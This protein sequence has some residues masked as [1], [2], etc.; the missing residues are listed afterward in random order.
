MLPKSPITDR[1]NVV[2]EKEIQ[3]SH[4][5]ELY[6]KDLKMDVG[7]FF[8]SLNKIGLY[9]CL[10][11]GY[12][13]FYPFNVAGDDD[14]YQQLDKF[15]WYYMDSKWEHVIAAQFV[16]SGEKV[17][18]IGCARGGFLKRLK[19]KGALVTGLELNTEAAQ[20]CTKDGFKVKTETIENYSLN[21]K[22]QYDVVCSFQVVEHISDIRNF[23]RASV[24]VL[25][26]GGKMIVSVP[27]NE[28]L[29]FRSGDICL[30]MPPHHMG[31]WEMNSLIKLQDYFD[32][33]VDSIH[34]EPLQKYHSG[35]A[36]KFAYKYVAEKLKR[37]GIL[38]KLVAP[39]ANRFART[40]VTAVTDFII[41]HSIVIV[42][43][44][45]E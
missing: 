42:F 11:T 40:G 24:E 35:Y 18:E 41:G 2:L 15:P 28:S 4:I 31:L 5:I 22:S 10:D 12:R 23:I 9:R 3:A 29:I 37:I 6:K 43:K 27:N 19:E 16:N 25:K 17:L 21:N 26:P 39:F 34:L 45:N 8:K 13:F 1:N 38:A 32:I 20:A 14:F 36:M 33:R 44:K 7:H 30:N